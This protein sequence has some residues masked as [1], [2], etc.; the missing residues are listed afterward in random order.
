MAS[1][2]HP[3]SPRTTSASVTVPML[4]SAGR[5]PCRPTWIKLRPGA[6]LSRPRLTYQARRAAS[7][8]T[9]AS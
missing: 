6:T 1:P 8:V 2:T 3:G 7:P 4:A 5:T 9:P